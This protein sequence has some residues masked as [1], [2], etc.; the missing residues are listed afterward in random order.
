MQKMKLIKGTWLLPERHATQGWTEDWARR[1]LCATRVKLGRRF[2]DEI[3]EI[4]LASVVFVCRPYRNNKF[5]LPPEKVD[6]VLNLIARLQAAVNSPQQ[7]DLPRLND[8]ADENAS[9]D[10]SGSSDSDVE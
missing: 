3:D 7:P 4:E 6:H 5:K 9:A 2:V 10:G 8:D 1:K